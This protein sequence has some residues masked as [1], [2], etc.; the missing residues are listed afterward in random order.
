MSSTTRIDNSKRNMIYGLFCQVITILFSFINRQIFIILLGKE[1]LGIHGLFAN[2]LTLLSLTEM[3]I[4][5]AFL[6]F[7][8]KPIRDRDYI[9][10]RAL[11]NF[12]RKLFIY[13]AV[14]VLVLGIIVVPLLPLIVDVDMEFNKIRL[15]YIIYLMNSVLSYFSVNKSMIIEAD[16][17]NFVISSFRTVIQ[18]IQNIAQI[19]LLLLFH[20]Y[21]VYLLVQAGCTILY[22]ISITYKAHKMY[23]YVFHGKAEQ[24][25]KENKKSI[26]EMIRATLIYKV[27]IV[28]MN[29]TDNLL[30]SI[31]I[32]T[33]SVGY[34]SNYRM[35][36]SVISQFV[37]VLIRAITASLGD[38]NAENNQEHSLRT[39]KMLVF[40]F[41]GLS[42]FCSICLLLCI[43]DFILLW[44]G[45]A[46]LLNMDVVIAMIFCFY[47]SN[48]ITP[49]W[50]YR[51]TMGLYQETKYLMLLAAFINL[52]LS[53][54]LGNLIGLS[55]IIAATG[56]ARILT[57]VWYEPRILFKKRFK[58][59]VNAYYVQQI[60]YIMQSLLCVAVIYCAT[61]HFP[62]SLIGMFGKVLVTF[63]VVLLIFALFNREKAEYTYLKKM[64]KEIVRKYK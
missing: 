45:E 18:V 40:S 15:Y 21:M 48:I 56:I 41:H 20:D 34:Y 46:Y 25:N 39:F 7:L 47:V 17:K 43:N 50:V 54:V 24:L 13:V 64:V 62:V 36:E 42:V 38:L 6:F 22:N 23:P 55:G 9:K 53:A 61:K 27:G 52:I 5:N 44:I 10:L 29:N 2:I 63:I 1:Y 14:L 11:L 37:S 26:L 28:V 4:G 35:V 51:E 16:Q 31:I 60:G 59:N 12:C 8:Y 58:E 33:V 19:L 32:T 49:V 3:G 30:I 57:T